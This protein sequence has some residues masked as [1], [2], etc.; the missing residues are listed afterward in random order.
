MR[1]DEPRQAA[2]LAA[3]STPK[4]AVP[5]PPAP[6]RARPHRVSR[7]SAVPFVRL[8]PDRRQLAQAQLAYLLSEELGYQQYEL[9]RQ[10]ALRAREIADPLIAKQARRVR[11]LIRKIERLDLVDP[12]GRSKPKSQ[13]QRVQAQKRMR[14]HLWRQFLLRAHL[15][16]ELD[17][18]ATLIDDDP[19]TPIAA[20]ET[21]TADW[22]RGLFASRPETAPETAPA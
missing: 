17:T 6:V 22:S 21:M 3:M 20:F 13:K 5:D 16:V 8:D 9:A 11:R 12:A 19:L 7:S 1:L 2:K 4:P 10:V 15:G 18:L 14:Q